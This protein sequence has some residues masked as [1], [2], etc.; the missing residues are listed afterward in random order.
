MLIDGAEALPRIARE[1]RE[2]R[3]HVYVMGWFFSPGFDLTRGDAPSPLR[4]LLAEIAERADVRVLAWAGSPMPLFHPSRKMVRAMR[5][6]LCRG[7]D[8]L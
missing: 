8:V 1:L 7:T 5:D 6:S 2:A 4:E 3:S